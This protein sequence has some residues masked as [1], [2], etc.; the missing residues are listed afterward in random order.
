MSVGEPWV[1]ALAATTRSSRAPQQVL[2]RLGLLDTPPQESVDRLT[3]LVSRLL[4]IPVSMV[5]LIDSERQFFLSQTGLGEP[6]AARRETPLSHSFCKHV[7]A[8][9]R[10]LVVEDARLDLE[11]ADSQA[12]TELGVIAYAGI[13]LLVEGE[14]IGALC[15]IDTKPRV[16]E[17]EDLAVLY[18]ITAAVA[19]QI[20]LRSALEQ[21]AAL[22]TTDPLTGLPNRRAW[23]EHVERDIARVRRSGRPLHLALLDLDRFK[24]FNDSHGHAAG[25]ELLCEFAGR[26]QSVLRETDILARWG[27]EEFAVLLSE[28]SSG[29]LAMSVLERVR[30]TVPCGQTCSVGHAVWDGRETPGQLM[31]R[32]DI[33]LYAAKTRGRDQIASSPV[34]LAERTPT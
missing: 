23:D 19:S 24:A 6:W 28:C 2:R 5:S 4:E 27:G 9:G 21:L 12:I 25:D 26:A 22:A 29:R 11:L 15:A 34:T 30:Q 8:E 33:A 18:D 3:R 13:P 10:R 16:W 1:P 17:P 14:C 32:A 31:R 7:A 20:A